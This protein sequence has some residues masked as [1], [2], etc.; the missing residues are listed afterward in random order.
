MHLFVS[1]CAYFKMA[2]NNTSAEYNCDENSSNEGYQ[3][4]DMGDSESIVPDTDPTS[5]D[6][7]ASSVGS[8]EVSSEHTD[9]RNE[10]DDNWPNIVNDA[11]VTANVNIPNW[12]TNFTDRTLEPVLWIVAPSY[13]QTLMFLWQQ[14]Y[15]TSICYSNQ[16]YFSD[17]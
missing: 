6:T 12:I 17:I 11:T 4:E 9:F 14:H 2:E 16:K 5:S 15:T 10:C 8:I 1:Y 13:L 3:N 7:E